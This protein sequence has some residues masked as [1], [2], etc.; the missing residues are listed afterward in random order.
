MLRQDDH[1]RPIQLDYGKEDPYG[2]IRREAD[3]VAGGFGGWRQIAAAFSLG[4]IG[5]LLGWLM[6]GG[7]FSAFLGVTGFAIGLFVRVPEDRADWR[8]IWSPLLWGLAFGMVGWFLFRRGGVFLGVY[9]F[10]V[11]RALLDEEL[12]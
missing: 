7:C 6:F 4:A 12:R 10:Q 5:M 3:A 1:T 8:R 2:D 9:G 11:G